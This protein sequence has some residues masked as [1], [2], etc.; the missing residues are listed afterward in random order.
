MCVGAGELAS[1][2][3]E[4]GMESATRIIDVWMQHPSRRFRQL[5]MFDSLRRWTHSETPPTD[6]PLEVTLSA[7]DEAGV[8]I[9]LLSA[10]WGPHG[11]LIGN[12]EVA[13]CVQ[14]YP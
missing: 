6:M 9:G 1:H 14:R 4:S 8:Q 3:R 10:W 11:P 5:S 12:D 7:M 2:R 13:R